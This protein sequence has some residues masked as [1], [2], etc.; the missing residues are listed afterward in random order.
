MLSP[1]SCHSSNKREKKMGGREDQQVTKEIKQ[2]Q[3]VQNC[4]YEEGDRVVVG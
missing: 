1:W 2:L 4:V 3:I